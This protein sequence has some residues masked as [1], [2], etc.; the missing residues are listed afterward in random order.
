M[1][2]ALVTGG[3]EG[4]GRAIAARFAQADYQVV[5]AARDAA[6][7]TTAASELKTQFATPVVPIPTDVRDPEQVQD[8]IQQIM[9]DFGQLDVL[10]NNAGL[11]S[12]G[13]TEEFTLEDWHQV[14]DTNLWGYIHT[15]HAA[16]PHMIAKKSGAIMNICSIAGKM[17]MPY[18]TLYT[19]SKFAISGLSQ[20]LS[21]ELAPKG[22]QVCAIYP[23]IIQTNFPEKAV[24]QGKDLVD[25]KARYEQL[26]QTLSMPFIEQPEDVAD[27]VWSALERNESEHIF[28]SAKLMG[29]LH[30]LVPGLTQ[31]MLR[32]IFKNKDEGSK[33]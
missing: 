33:I 11:Y 29:G 20:A 3:S 12:S 15:I 13:P 10:V 24:M 7:L 25:Q 22:V 16:L 18:L 9:T 19:T 5:I 27:A 23:N 8:L 6:K 26:E 28:G 21:A 4:I 1:K 31:R 2:V 17:P 32:T 14:I 30:A